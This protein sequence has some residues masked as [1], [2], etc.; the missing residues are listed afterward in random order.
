MEQI[1]IYVPSPRLLLFTLAHVVVL[2][3]KG[4]CFL[5]PFVQAVVRAFVPPEL[6]VTPGL[7]AGHVVE[8]Q[9]IAAK[10]KD[11]LHKSASHH[12]HR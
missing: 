2:I 12:R 1:G 9:Y 7:P 6:H 5:S 10:F 4:F 11:A 3:G 8:V